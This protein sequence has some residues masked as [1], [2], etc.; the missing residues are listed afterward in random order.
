[1]S[2]LKKL[3][4]A[5]VGV[6][7]TAGTIISAFGT[8]ASAFDVNPTTDPS[9]LQNSLFG[10]TSGLSNIT[11]S[12]TG[13]P[14]AI[15]LFSGANVPFNIN[16]GVVLSTGNVEDTVGPNSSTN[17][18]TAFGGIP[19]VEDLAQID[20]TFDADATVNNLFFQY[21]FGSEEFP[22]FVNAGVNDSFQLLLNGVNLA[23]LPNGQLVN[24]DNL[25]PSPDLISNPSG[26]PDTQLDGYTR[27]LDFVGPLNQNAS[28][29]LS[30][31]IQDVGDSILD[32]AVFIRGNS[33][34]T[35]PPPPPTTPI[36]FE[37]SPSLGLLALGAWGAIAQLNSIVQ[38][39]KSSGSA[40]AKN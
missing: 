16:S 38:K 23:T 5:T 35:A 6:T 26:N 19:G 30:I 34:G 39:R 33:I 8:P 36:P 12:V 3:S 15:G 25:G 2:I 28:N 21:V 37:F 13:D 22:E 7:I 1:M 11:V 31:Q 32:S 17:Q 14:N 29:T 10:S 40:I 20:F 9:N 4:L 27:V 18:S 24:V